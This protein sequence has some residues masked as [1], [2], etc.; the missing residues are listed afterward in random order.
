VIDIQIASIGGLHIGEKYRLE[1]PDFALW[2][3][4][5]SAIYPCPNGRP[6]RNA[7]TGH[8]RMVSEQH[9]G[10]PLFGL[11]ATTDPALKLGRFF[12]VMMSIDA[13]EGVGIDNLPK[14]VSPC[15]GVVYFK[16]GFGPNLIGHAEQC[17]SFNPLV[18]NINNAALIAGFRMIVYDGVFEKRVRKR[19]YG[20]LTQ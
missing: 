4:V 13:A 1:N 3:F 6:I 18:K 5:L 11:Q 19:T 12:E 10:P 15:D 20:N 17:L 2:T 16:C 7:I 14:H 8:Q 9:R